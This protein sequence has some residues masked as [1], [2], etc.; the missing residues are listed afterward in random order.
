MLEVLDAARIPY[1]PLLARLA[2]R[3][4]RDPTARI[5]WEPFVALVEAVEELCGDALSLEEIGAR[6]LRVPSFQF[7]RLTGQ[8]VVSPRQLYTVGERLVAP[9]MFSN[10]TV[11]NQWLP[12]GRLIVTAELASGYRQSGAILRIASANVVALPRLLDLPPS[13]IEEQLVTGQRMRLILV[14]PA[15]H[16]IGARLRRGARAVFALGDVFRGVARQQQELEGSIAALRTS[17]HELRQLLE[18]LPEGVL[19]HRRGSVIWANAAV[20]ESL[21]YERLDDVIGHNLLDF[22][23]PEDRAQIATEMAA[24]MPNEVSDERRVYRVLRPDGTVRRLQSG[25]TQHVDFAGAQARL[26]VLRDVTEQHRLRDQLA[27]AE[28]MALLGRLAAGVAHEIN[29]PLAYT[30]ASV[31]VAIREV[32]TLGDPGRSRTLE[33]SLAR[34]R[35]GTERVRGIVRDLKMLSRADDEASESVDLPALLDSTLALAANAIAPKARV[36]R[37]YRDAPSARATR[38]RLGQL[39]L[40]LLLNATDAIPEGNAEQHEIR[41]RISRDGNGDAVVEISDTGIGIAPE[42]APRVFDPFFTTKPVGSGT[43]LGLAICHQIVTELGGKIIFESTPRSGTTFRVT[44][45]AGDAAQPVA[46]AQARE[47]RRARVL[48]VDDE[49]ALLRSIGDLIG[50]EHD[51][52][53]ASSGRQALDVLRVDREFD[54]ILA[55]LMMADVTGMDLFDVVRS[56]HPELERR[57][58]FMTGGAFTL[59][60][61]TLLAS[62]ANRCIEKPF[63]GAELLRVIGDA[64]QG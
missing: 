59:R 35:E 29:N 14:P 26:I 51:I 46:P 21:G 7:L 31:E 6:M 36:T 61:R 18:R 55:D 45:P 63:D 27:L 2:I 39:F 30:Q 32:A 16:T 20:L 22:V 11:T 13:T 19:I 10:I 62:T 57:F 56:D 4:D 17:R 25:T 33:E 28:R 44:L 60:G 48:I 37:D 9:A 8:L 1:E 42:L 49:P 54:V 64:V 38:G 12:A 47:M 58:V 40:N 5:D 34:A 3:I 50:E 23:P 53:T 43:G 15:S 24:A 52:V 41:V